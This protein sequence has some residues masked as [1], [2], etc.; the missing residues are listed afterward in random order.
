[1][2]LEQNNKK[3]NEI[4][5][6][7]LKLSLLCWLLSIIV[8]AIIFCL[9]I[10]PCDFAAK[11]ANL[12][13]IYITFYITLPLLAL[14][15]ARLTNNFY[16]EISAFIADKL[17]LLALFAT[18]LIAGAVLTSS[19][20][21]SF[22]I[23]VPIIH[24]I[25][26]I[27]GFTI[28]FTII[29]ILSGVYLWNCRYNN[30]L[31]NLAEFSGF[32]IAI[33][34]LVSILCFYKSFLAVKLLLQ[35]YPLDLCHYYELIFWGG[36]LVLQFA[37]TALM[38]YAWIIILQRHLSLGSMQDLYIFILM[39]HL[40]LVIPSPIIYAYCNIDDGSYHDFFNKQAS[41]FLQITP[42]IMTIIMWIHM[43]WQ[44]QKLKFDDM[45]L[46]V[47]ASQFLCCLTLLLN[48]KIGTPMAISGQYQPQI[49]AMT[50]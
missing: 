48:F 13:N 21:S 26:F 34:L 17:G 15:I 6:K 24:N 23:H 45:I 3:V 12:N 1:M 16:G 46:A 10:L 8:S 11:I 29:L 32:V 33:I 14:C 47:L 43:L 37:F 5:S 44:R 49:G 30:L 22:S 2:N 7:W 9:Q 38:L 19:S 31:N 28:F 41:Y 40:I 18:L 4:Y 50:A 35:E 39:F 25:L 42:I 27:L 36:S 20:E